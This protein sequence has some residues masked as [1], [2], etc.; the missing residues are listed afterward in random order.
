MLRSSPKQSVIFT[1]SAWAL[2]A[3]A[4]IALPAAAAISDTVHPFVSVGYSYEDNLLRLPDDTPGFTGSRSDTIRQEQAGVDFERPFGRQVLTAEAKVSRVNFDHYDQLN[5]NGK[6]YSAAWQWH[7]VENFDGHLGGAYSQT[8]TPFT[9]FHVSELNLRTTRHEYADGTWRFFPSWQVHTG[10]TRDKFNY[11]LDIQQFN[12]RTEDAAEA[13]FDFLASSGSRFGFVA[14]RLRGSYQNQQSIG[15]IVLDNGYV[16]DEYKANVFWTVSGVTQVQ[17]LVGWAKRKHNFFTDRDSSGANGRATVIWRPLGLV[18]FTG[19]VWREFAAVESVLVNN[20]LNKGQSL[21]AS[22]DA[23]AK[24]R[25]DASLRHEKRDFSK[26]SGIVIPGSSTDVSRNVTAGVTYL[27]QQFVQFGIS[28]FHEKR[29]GSP[30]IGTGDYTA[31][32][33]SLTATGQ[34]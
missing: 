16:Q 2:L 28:V 22:W 13:G 34:F 29:N 32:G 24:L 23:S 11:D 1:R 27:P 33:V 21:E 10:F 6:D 7:L 14:R 4:A 31:N 17:A 26:L 8:L 19:I 20:S 18:K 5:Y 3:G 12:N 25:V 9:D 15:N 30:Y